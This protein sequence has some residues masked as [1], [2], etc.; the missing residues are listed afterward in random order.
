[1]NLALRTTDTLHQRRF[2]DGLA[3]FWKRIVVA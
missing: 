3:E 2:L 1:M